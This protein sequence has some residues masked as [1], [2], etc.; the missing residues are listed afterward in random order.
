VVQRLLSLLDIDYMDKYKVF[1]LGV[2]FP[3]NAVRDLVSHLHS[4][5]QQYIVMIDPGQCILATSQL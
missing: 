3:L 5:N 2:N 4:N 1:T